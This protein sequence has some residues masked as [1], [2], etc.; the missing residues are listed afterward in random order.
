MRQSRTLYMFAFMPPETKALEIHDHRLGFAENY[1]FTKALK[2]P[3][4]ITLLDPFFI[5]NDI[6]PLFEDKMYSL[7]DWAAQQNSF[8]I[9][10]Q[11]FGFFENPI[12]PLVYI[13]VLKN[14][15]LNV[16]RD[17][18]LNRMRRHY[19]F[20]IPRR[21]YKPHITIG[22][23][24][25]PPDAFPWIKEDYSKRR[26]KDGFDCNAFYLWKHNGYNWEVIH[27]F[28]LKGMAEQLVLF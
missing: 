19:D 4:H 7:Q 9:E 26:F 18:F 14:Q 23:R 16:L 11:D 28:P 8:P 6:A 2:P 21:S 24:D 15:K 27:E 10:L 13:N 20:D 22:Y 1:S 5:D 12:N 25:I 3:V 17:G